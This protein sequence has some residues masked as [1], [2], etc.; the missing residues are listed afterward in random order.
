MLSPFEE[1]AMMDKEDNEDLFH[2]QISVRVAVWIT[3][4]LSMLGALLI[5]FSY[6]CFKTM[7]SRAR[8]ILVHISVMDFLVAASNLTGAAVDFDRFYNCTKGTDSCSSHPASVDYWCK[9][10]AF[11]A[12]YCTLG[13][14]LWTVSLSVYLYFLI[15]HHGTKKAKYSL[16]F[17]YFFCYLLPLLL[18]LWLLLTGRLGYSPYQSA[19]WCGPIFTNPLT[20][21]RY[22]YVAVISYDLW[23]YLTFIIVPILFISVHFY[24]R[25]EVGLHS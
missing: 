6:V 25:S 4:S 8:E 10:Q 13:S 12:I 23:I 14:V 20:M 21:Q 9:T 22:I 24:I 18:T 2:K 3:C 1:A 17:S 15:T 19:M 16:Y 5:I 11:F 7:R